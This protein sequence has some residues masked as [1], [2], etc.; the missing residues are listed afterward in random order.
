MVGFEIFGDPLF[1]V[2][3]GKIRISR[4]N[5]AIRQAHDERRIG[6]V[7]VEVNKEARIA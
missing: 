5:G 3:T 1:D 2:C 7:P 6:G 4:D